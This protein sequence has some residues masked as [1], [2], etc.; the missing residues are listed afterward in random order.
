MPPRPTRFTNLPPELIRRIMEP[1]DAYAVARAQAASRTVRSALRN[2]L[3]G[4]AT[5]MPGAEN[6]RRSEPYDAHVMALAH[7][8]ALLGT[9]TER[10][11]EHY[12]RTVRRQWQP[13]ATTSAQLPIYLSL[14]YSIIADYWTKTAGELRGMGR[15]VF[16]KKDGR[17]TT[18]L[19]KVTGIARESATANTAAWV[20]ANAGD[21]FDYD[22][23]HDGPNIGIIVEIFARPN[24]HGVKLEYFIDMSTPYDL[25]NPSV[26][27]G[28][29]RH[30]AFTKA[31]LCSITN[32]HSD[33]YDESSEGRWAEGKDLVLAEGQV[34]I[35]MSLEQVRDVLRVVHLLKRALLVAFRGSVRLTFDPR[36]LPRPFGRLFKMMQLV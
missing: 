21:D 24:V 29:L 32:L 19:Q 12:N 8:I 36:D 31:G 6:I 3:A 1:A 4:P 16:Y 30:V 13:P 27:A 15:L 5:P 35:S 9:W 25:S 23:Y 18:S 26:S 2:R 17:K 10:A 34:R 7:R 20:A 14:R 28:V 22:D 11:I 33:G